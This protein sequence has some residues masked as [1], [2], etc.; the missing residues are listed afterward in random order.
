LITLKAQVIGSSVRDANTTERGS[1]PLRVTLTLQTPEFVF[2]AEGPATESSPALSQLPPGS[3]VELTGICILQIA[4][5]GRMESLHLLLSGADSVRVIQAPS[6]L[7]PKRLLHGVALLSLILLLAVAWIATVSRKNATLKRLVR[8]NTKVQ[9]DLQKSHDTLDERVRERTAQLKFETSEREEAEVRFKATL[10]ERTRLAQELH[11]T[12]EQSLTG[13]GLQLE[14]ATKL[15]K[16]GADGAQ[17]P[18]DVARILLSRSHSELRQSI[19]DLRSRELEQFDL[20]NAIRM[21]AE[22]ILEGTVVEVAFKIV[23]QPHPL[24]E[25]VEENLLRI[26]REACANVVKHAK[27]GRVNIQLE[28]GPDTVKLQVRDDGVGFYPAEAPDLKQG[29]FGLLGISERTKRFNG[30]LTVD[31]APGNGTN[32][33]VKI[34]TSDLGQ[35]QTVAGSGNGR[36]S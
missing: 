23:G 2:T 22:D 18:L 6:W 13:I 11:D 29:H 10:A 31:S 14:T 28:F 24:S 25:V 30:T 17:R 16:N 7:T 36:T 15:F 33:E 34:P 3:I 19:W 35:R 21:G 4:D 12:T 5:D 20:P 8:E 27:A 26:A 1:V 9:E 32:L